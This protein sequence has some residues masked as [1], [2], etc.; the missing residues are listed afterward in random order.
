M[1]IL[2]VL[3]SGPQV[4]LAR[5]FERRNLRGE[6]YFVGRIGSARVVVVPTGTVSRGEPVWQLVVGEGFFEEHN[7]PRDRQAEDAKPNGAASASNG[8]KPTL[9]LPAR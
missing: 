7:L 3:N 1:D 8:R 5:L 2:S 6:H 4:A 9:S